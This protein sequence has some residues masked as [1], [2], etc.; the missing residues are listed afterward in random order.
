[1][2]RRL[3]EGAIRHPRPFPHRHA[4]V[5]PRSCS[6]PPSADIYSADA[7]SSRSTA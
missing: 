5:C 2:C 3:P 1:M 4:G 7:H 6:L